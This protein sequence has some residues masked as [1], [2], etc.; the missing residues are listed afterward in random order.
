MKTAITIALIACFAAASANAKELETGTIMVCDTQQQVAR[1]GL[2]FDGNN[3]QTAISAVNGEEANACGVAEA[4]YVKGKPVAT[5]RNKSHT[6]HVVPVIVVGINTP[7]GFQAVDSAV[8]FTLVQVK[9]FA[10]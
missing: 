10:I 8:L 6:F 7:G 3:A 2:L 1:V 9:E 5:V 4:T